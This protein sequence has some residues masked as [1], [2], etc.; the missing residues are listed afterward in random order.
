MTEERWHRKKPPNQKRQR[1]E[2][3]VV[4]QLQQRIAELEAASS[5]LTCMLAGTETAGIA[6][7]GEL[8]VRRATPAAAA[9]FEVSEGDVGRHLGELAPGGDDPHLLADAQAVLEQAAPLER[10]VQSG[11]RW[12]MRRILPCRTAD[13]A[14]D[15]VVVTWTEITGV[16][17]ATRQLEERE[18][19]QAVVA[20]LCHAALARRDLQSLLVEAVAAVRD[21]LQTELVCVLERLSDA[22]KLGLRAGTGWRAGLVGNTLV[23]ARP[24]TQT[25]C[26]LRSPKP[27]IVDDLRKQKR[28]LGPALLKQH[29][30]ISGISVAIGSIDAP[31]GVLGAYAGRKVTFGAEDAAFVQSVAE[32][33]A[34]VIGRQRTEQAMR[35]DAQRLRLALEVASAGTW[36]W[37]PADDRIAWDARQAEIFGLEPERPPS[38]GRDFFAQVHPDDL[39]ELCAA[40]HAALRDA[41]SYQA[42]FRLVRADGTT[43]W[44]ASRGAVVNAAADGA[45]L[46]LG[47]DLD[48]TERRQAEEALRTSEERFRLAMH[49]VAGL[50]YDWDIHTDR[51]YRSERLERLIGVQPE[52]TDHTWRWLKDRMHPDDLAALLPQLDAM[53]EGDATSY[54]FEYRLRHAEGHWVHV[55]DRGCIQRD[56]GG[57]AV[58][59]VGSNSDITERKRNEERQSLLMA[60][61]DH[62][63][64]NILASITAITRQTRAE[65]RSIDDF[66]RILSGRIEAMGRAHSLLS[67]S[68]WEGARL[69]LLL[70]QELARYRRAEAD[71]VSIT[72][73][74]VVLRPKAAQSLAVALHELTTNAVRHGALSTEQGRVDIAWRLAADE[75]EAALHLEWRERGGPPVATASADGF[76]TLVLRR[77]LAHDLGAAVDLAYAQDG[78]VCRIA[79]PARHIVG[80][81]RA[82]DPARTRLSAPPGQPPGLSGAVLMVEDSAVVAAE[83]A[84]LLEELGCRV[85]GPAA[86]LD[87]A[88]RFAA[89]NELDAAVL[90][91]NLN[92]TKVYPLADQLRARRVPFI[93]ITGYEP[94]SALHER[95]G[96]VPCLAKPVQPLAVSSALA[97]ILPHDNRRPE[98]PRVA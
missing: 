15:G 80:V 84:G 41:G 72:G 61:L 44:V 47:V 23:D 16:K 92:G 10:E 66:V 91:I 45:P 62:R 31:W 52:A 30:V 21:T 82:G 50:I 3:S 7:D 97:R 14:G 59:A 86:S 54:A 46:L 70:D 36:V 6:L 27:I 56:A 67:Q 76:G 4:A 19:R 78:L 28:F 88:V 60:E 18:R 40:L 93:F 68:R 69:Q 83:I 53:L 11:A 17:T 85:V 55:W 33:L 9:P 22:R 64:R 77:M 81:N 48:I 98:R 49:A 89:E 37:N 90:D 32:V 87:E 24:N 43:R 71:P 95:F 57:R 29:G 42:E 20:Q 65:G 35:D 5:A 79:L 25:G 73:E 38:W 34:A 75:A 13:Q 94:A 26:T 12:F 2:Q 8:R 63:V 51:T 39:P 74:H 96:D 1:L 58:R